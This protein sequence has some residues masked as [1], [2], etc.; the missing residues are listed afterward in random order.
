[1]RTNFARSTT[2]KSQRWQQRH[3][4]T[5]THTHTSQGNIIDDECDM[6][7]HQ[8][9]TMKRKGRRKEVSGGHHQAHCCSPTTWVFFKHLDKRANDA[10]DAFVVG[11][12]ANCEEH[13]IVFREAEGFP[14]VCSQPRSE[15]RKQCKT[16]PVPTPTRNIRSTRHNH[17]F[18]SES[19]PY[20]QQIDS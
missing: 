13:N 18:T 20:K 17:H 14:A 12:G 5:H 11:H 8:C 6:F 10:R 9:S 19:Q 4:T 3:N 7:S 2:G 1:M 15:T 16:L